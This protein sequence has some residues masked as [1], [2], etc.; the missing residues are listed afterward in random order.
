MEQQQSTKNTVSD[1]MS[2]VFT[3]KRRNPP[4]G[5]LL[6][7]LSCDSFL[8]VS[9]SAAHAPKNSFSAAMQSMW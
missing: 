7:L 9:P 2:R 1:R 4:L 6:L 3:K 8:S 5:R